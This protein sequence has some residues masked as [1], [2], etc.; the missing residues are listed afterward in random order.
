M[1]YILAILSLGLSGYV[2]TKIL[3]GTVEEIAGG[4]PKARL[5]QN[6]AAWLVGEYGASGASGVVT[7]IGMGAALVFMLFR[8]TRTEK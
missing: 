3:N 5:L 2:S 1:R 4:S 8:G 6:G 7:L